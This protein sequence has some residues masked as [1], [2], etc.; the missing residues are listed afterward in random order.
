MFR[1]ISVFLVLIALFLS[2]WYFV[3]SFKEF[4]EPYASTMRLYARGLT[5]WAKNTWENVAGRKS[6]S[7][8]TTNTI[9]RTTNTTDT[10]TGIMTDSGSRS[11]FDP[12]LF[13]SHPE[14]H[15]P[16]EIEYTNMRV[17]PFSY[18]QRNPHEEEEVVE[19]TEDIVD[20]QVVGIVLNKGSHDK[21]RVVVRFPHMSESIMMAAGDTKAGYTLLEIGQDKLTFVHEMSPE[22]FEVMVK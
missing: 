12:E 17:S 7:S 4:V 9:Q 10:N 21:S 8:P 5:D 19:L 14:P 11:R 20:V 13:N 22:R 18:L 1:V 6:E 3:P 16:T 2:G 15:A